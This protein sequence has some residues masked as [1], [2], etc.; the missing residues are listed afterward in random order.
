VFNTR[1]IKMMDDGGTS[2]VYFRAFFDSRKD[3][4]ETDTHYRCQTGTASF[5]YRLIYKLMS[6][7]KDWKLTI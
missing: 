5:N 1:D 7:K 3:A 6:D 4:A 2:D